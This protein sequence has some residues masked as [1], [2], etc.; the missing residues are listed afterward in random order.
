MIVVTGGTKGIGKAIIEKFASEGYSIATCSRNEQDLADLKKEI[1]NRFDVGVHT[2]VADLS[3]KDTCQT[4]AQFVKDISLPVEVLVNNTGVFIPGAI[5]NEADG[6]LETQIETN[7]YSAYYL[8]RALIGGMM[9]RKAGY[10]FNMCSIASITAYANGGSYAISKHALH[11]F[12]KCLREE[13]KPHGVRVSSVMPGA[14]L[15]ASWAGVDIPPERFMKAEDVAEVVWCNFRLSPQTVVE[16]IVLR[17]Q[18]GD[19]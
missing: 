4:F 2:Q 7:L 15:T 18:L 11:G 8:T 19:L 3:S 14:T 17:P 12:S 10:I 5:H 13:M 1:E 9:E 6:L 16:D